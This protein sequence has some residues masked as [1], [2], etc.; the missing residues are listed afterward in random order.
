[1]KEKEKRLSVIK[2]GKEPGEKEEEERL[3]D[4]E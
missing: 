4:C 2:E 3:G 1:M